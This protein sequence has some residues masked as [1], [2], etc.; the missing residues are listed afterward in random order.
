MS[1][2]HAFSLA[3]GAGACRQLYACLAGRPGVLAPYAQPGTAP[4]RGRVP[5]QDRVPGLLGEL[6]VSI[7]LQ[8]LLHLRGRNAMGRALRGEDMAGGR[9]VE[10]WVRPG[11]A[12]PMGELHARRMYLGPGI[13]SKVGA[14]RTLRIS[15]ASTWLTFLKSTS[16]S[17]APPSATLTP[18]SPAQSRGVGE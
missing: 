3:H 8:A 1:T 16:W 10:G 11:W 7:D 6:V 12:E 17:S 4:A 18:T 13:R 14:P 15:N 9:G 2:K 5:H